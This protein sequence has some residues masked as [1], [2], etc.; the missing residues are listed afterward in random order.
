MGKAWHVW[1]VECEAI[2]PGVVDYGE[3]ETLLLWATVHTRDQHF[4][5]DG[6]RYEM[7]VIYTGA[8]VH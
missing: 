2:S 5:L 3:R 6:D 1:C 7:G 4:G 8:K